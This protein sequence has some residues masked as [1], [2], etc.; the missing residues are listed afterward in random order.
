MAR[1]SPGEDVQA[2][3]AGDDQ[4]GRSLLDARCAHPDSAFL[5]GD[6]SIGEFYEFWRSVSVPVAVVANDAQENLA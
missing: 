2:K 1:V 5:R 6:E 4:L 3:L